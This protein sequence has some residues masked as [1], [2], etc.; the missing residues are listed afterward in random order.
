LGVAYFEESS[1]LIDLH[2]KDSW[3]NFAINQK[4]KSPVVDT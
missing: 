3:A 1:K 4:V 2:R